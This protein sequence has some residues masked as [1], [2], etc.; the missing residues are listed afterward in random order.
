[1]MSPILS[2]LSKQLERPEA[3][4]LVEDLVDQPLAL[5]AVQER[6]L[7][8]AELLDDAPDLVAQRLGVDLGDAV[9]VEPVDQPHVDVALERL[10]LLLGRVDF[11]GGPRFVARLR[12]GLAARARVASGTGLSPAVAGV[13]VGGGGSARRARAPE[14]GAS[15]GP[16]GLRPS[17]RNIGVDSHLVELLATV[18]LEEGREQASLGLGGFVRRGR[19]QRA[20]DLEEN[21]VGPASLGDLRERHTL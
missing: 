20:G 7:G 4:R 13:E 17:P 6:V 19:P 12:R 8:V 2:S 16:N 9:H 14:T 1:M 10:V 18:Q 3:E 5:V 11:L 21:L 15:R